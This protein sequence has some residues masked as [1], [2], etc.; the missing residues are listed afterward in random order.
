MSGPLAIMAGRSYPSYACQVIRG[1][2]PELEDVNQETWEIV[3]NYE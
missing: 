1:H 2:F 3:N